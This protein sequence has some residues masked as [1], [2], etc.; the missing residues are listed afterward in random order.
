MAAAVMHPL[1][2]PGFVSRYH[3]G[4]QRMQV[5]E[6]VHERLLWVCC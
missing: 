1:Q 5:S 6:H 2:P 4:E 3:V